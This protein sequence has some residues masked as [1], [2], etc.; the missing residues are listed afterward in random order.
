MKKVT[1]NKYLN[2]HLSIKGKKRFICKQFIALFLF[3]ACLG[4]DAFLFH[5]VS[6][7][8]ST[9]KNA[10]LAFGT[11]LLLLVLTTYLLFNILQAK[12]FYK[13]QEIFFKTK[14]FDKLKTKALSNINKANKQKLKEYYQLHLIDKKTMQD[15]L[16]KIKKH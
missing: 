8:N 1:T 14:E 5:V 12:L 10:L 7:S 3:L 15:C 9:L 16:A 2:I 11:I 6:N 13:S 4:T